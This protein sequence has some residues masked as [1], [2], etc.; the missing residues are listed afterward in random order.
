MQE[1]RQRLSLITA[2]GTTHHS[3]SDVGILPLPWFRAAIP[4]GNCL[5]KGPEQK[6]SNHAANQEL[7]AEKDKLNDPLVL[8]VLPANSWGW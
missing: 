1:E 4:S 8:S 7:Q 2:Q 3:Y 6:S 5:Q